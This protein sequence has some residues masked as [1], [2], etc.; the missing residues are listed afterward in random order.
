MY[1]THAI[2]SGFWSQHIYIYQWQFFY[3]LCVLVDGLY[4]ACP[5]TPAYVISFSNNSWH[6]QLVLT[7]HQSLNKVQPTSLIPYALLPPN[8]PPVIPTWF[9]VL[10]ALLR[11]LTNLIIIVEFVEP[12]TILNTMLRLQVVYHL[13][14][15]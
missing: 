7:S 13:E 12:S 6:L 5:L 2:A 1:G 4:N 9:I 15:R 3:T 10:P 14:H 8:F 11:S